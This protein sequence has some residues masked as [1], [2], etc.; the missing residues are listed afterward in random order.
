MS[1]I[2]VNK[3]TGTSTAGSIVV[4]GEGN[5]TTTNL[6][7]GLAKLW[8]NWAGSA[9]VNNSSNTASVTDNGTGNFSINTTN[10]FANVNYCRAGFATNTAGTS[11]VLIDSTTTITQTD[12]TTVISIEVNF[13]NDSAYDGNRDEVIVHGDLA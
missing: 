6:Q 13:L 9:T 10:A 5:S 3:L 1:E 8:C 7:Q 12:S 2:L 11:G 4:T